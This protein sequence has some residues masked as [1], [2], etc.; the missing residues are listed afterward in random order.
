MVMV[1][2]A[3]VIASAGVVSLRIAEDAGEA[4]DEGGV[5]KFG[6]CDDGGGSLCIACFVRVDDKE[7]RWVGC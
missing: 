1:L 5:V 4:R 3:S 6:V 7:V 2:G